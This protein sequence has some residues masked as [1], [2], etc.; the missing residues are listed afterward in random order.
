MIRGL[1]A[2]SLM[3]LAKL[4]NAGGGAIELT[5]ANFAETTKGKNSFVKFVSV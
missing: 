4:V 5:K 1:F 2:V 3:A